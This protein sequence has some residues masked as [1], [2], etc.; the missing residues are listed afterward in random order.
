[1]EIICYRNINTV[2]AKR[3]QIDNSVPNGK[4]LHI[5]KFGAFSKDKLTLF[6]TIPVSDDLE[7]D[8]F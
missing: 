5:T 4:M 8:G 1:M 2:R 3:S 7:E 6:Q